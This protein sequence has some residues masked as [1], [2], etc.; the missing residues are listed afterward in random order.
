[1]LHANKGHTK[2]EGVK[3]WIFVPVCHNSF[4]ALHIHKLQGESMTCL[5]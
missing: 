3:T 2:K 1:M 5:G 4:N